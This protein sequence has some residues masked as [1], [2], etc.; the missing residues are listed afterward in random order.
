MARDGVGW[1][2]KIRQGKDLILIVHLRQRE[3]NISLWRDIGAQ[4]TETRAQA[5]N[6]HL[7]F[8]SIGVHHGMPVDGNIP[9]QCPLAYHT[10]GP[11]L[12]HRQVDRPGVLS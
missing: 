2:D 6:T 5:W 11:V 10:T 7:A 1:R 8:A 12:W 4:Q 3:A 9:R